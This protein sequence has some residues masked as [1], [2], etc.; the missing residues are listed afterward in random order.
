VNFGPVPDVSLA[1]RAVIDERV[2]LLRS[3]VVQLPRVTIENGQH[4]GFCVLSRRFA[5]ILDDH[6][7]DG[8]VALTCMGA[9][10]LNAEFAEVFPDRFFIPAYTGGR[11]WIGLRLDQPTIDWDEVEDLCRD[12]YRLI[13]PKRLGDLVPLRRS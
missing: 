6:H 11:G 8:V 1:T 12:A 7:G 9:P 10:G 13:A 2:H 5:W 3:M 4:L